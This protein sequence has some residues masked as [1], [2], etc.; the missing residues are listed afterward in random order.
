VRIEGLRRGRGN[1][2]AP[3]RGCAYSFQID[4]A[5]VILAEDG[6]PAP[7]PLHGEPDTTAR[8]LS[9]PEP[10]SFGLDAVCYRIAHGVHECIAQRRQHLRIELYFTTMRLEIDLPPNAMSGIANG[11]FE[12]GKHRV[13]GDEAQA[14]RNVLDLGKAPFYTF[15]IGGQ[16][17]SQAIELRANLVD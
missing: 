11:S 4:A 12:S 14:M 9:G 2:T 10:L 7:A 13:G 8:R 6:D 17:A 1:E 3:H 5:P 16:A 15:G